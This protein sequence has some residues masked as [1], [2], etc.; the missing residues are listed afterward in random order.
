MLTLLT[1]PREVEITGLTADGEAVSFGVH[2]V[3]PPTAAEAIA[4]LEVYEV[5]S[6]GG[7]SPEDQADAFHVLASVLRSWLPSRL[8]SLLL[9]KRFPRRE[10]IGIALTLLSVGIPETYARRHEER[11]EEARREARRLGWQ[12]VEAEYLAFYGRDDLDKPW[13]LWLSRYEQ[14]D[15]QRARAE[16]STALSVATAWSGK[17]WDTIRKRL[18]QSGHGEISEEEQIAKLERLGARFQAS[19]FGFRQMPGEA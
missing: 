1:I 6:A 2:L 12:E 5:M 15:R 3:R 7:A 17:G 19:G 13:G 14:L 11:Q 8:W 10:A 4:V 18:G 16:L 9:A